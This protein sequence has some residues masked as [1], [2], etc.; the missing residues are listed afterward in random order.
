MISA[1]YKIT[2]PS[3][4]IYVGQSIHINKRI[5][6]YKNYVGNSSSIGPR[7]LNSF[8]KYGWES[9]KFE[10]IEE[11]EVNLLDLRETYWKQYYL[12]MLNNEWSQV[13]FCGLYDSGGGPK[14]DQT[15]SKMSNTHSHNLLK[16]EIL[17]KR[18]INCKNSSTSVSHERRLI[19]TNWEERNK[20]LNKPRT[21]YK[22]FQKIDLNDN[23]LKT[24]HNINDI[25]NEFNNPKP[26][27]L[28]SCLKGKYKTWMGYKWKGIK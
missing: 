17:A 19:N 8:Q 23:I 10:I 27:N 1:I 25:L 26:Q 2:S 12:D 16:P 20:K 6:Q 11:C 22:I 18:L 5:I 28:Y 15:K 24:Y 3:N 9:H 4:K 14:S 21:Y 13:L 7:L